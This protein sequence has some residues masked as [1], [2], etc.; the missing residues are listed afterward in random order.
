MKLVDVHAHLDFK[1]IGDQLS[2]YLDNAASVGVKAI[3]ANGVDPK[4]NRAVKALADQHDLIKPAFGFY[5]W[6]IPEHNES[7]FDEEIDFM[8]KNNPVAIGEVG[9]D[10][11]TSELE[12]YKT[13][14][15]DFDKI[16]KIQRDGFEKLISVAEKKKIPIIVHSRKAELETIEMLES[17]SVKKVI[18]HCF[19]GKKK[20][21]P[22]II[23][24]GWSFSIPVVVTKLQQMQELVKQT[25]LSQLLTETD[26][27]YLAPS[28]PAVEN[29]PLHSTGFSLGGDNES[30]STNNS[31]NDMPK[32][33]INE[34]ANVLLSIKKIAELKG[35]T[36]NEAADQVFMNYLKLF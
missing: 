34:S 20:L 35:L 7:T 18:M 6:H 4:S 16:K 19:M 2:T 1:P 32:I 30:N 29:S 9:L 36:E 25:P 13:L 17:S 22:R 11:K 15:S 24:N 26:A 23:D 28:S 31:V 27:P 10:F 12:N 21:I 14:S 33:P 3:I 5:P 8:K